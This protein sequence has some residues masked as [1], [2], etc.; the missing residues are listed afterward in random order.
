MSAEQQAL[1]LQLMVKYAKKAFTFSISV[2]AEG[3]TAIQSA[4]VLDSRN[5]T[6][7]A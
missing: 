2:G 6:C 3:I 1:Y 7:N 4:G 5:W